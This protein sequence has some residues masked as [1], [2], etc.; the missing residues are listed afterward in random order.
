MAK[1]IATKTLV[2][3]PPGEDEPGYLARLGR[4]YDYVERLANGTIGRQGI[5]E[6][7]AFL[8]NYI[9]RPEDRAKARSLLF[10]DVTRAQYLE[11]LRAIIRADGEDIL[12]FQNGS[13]LKNGSKG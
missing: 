5:E 11:M 1:E 13:D 3:S 7:A 6:L 12:P 10:N 9:T 4:V 2:F 8:L